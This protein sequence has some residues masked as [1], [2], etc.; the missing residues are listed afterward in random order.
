[1]EALHESLAAGV[2]SFG[3][4]VTLV[5]P[6]A[7]ATGFGSPA[8]LQQSDEME[9]YRPLR[10]HVAGRLKNQG[11]GDP[12]ASATAIL[13]LVDAEASPLRFILG[14]KN[15]PAARS[16]YAGR[17][18]GAVLWTRAPLCSG[19]GCW[20]VGLAAGSRPGVSPTTLVR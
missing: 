20:E 3:I 18:A 14:D 11:R 1:M 6:G 4:K 10:Q 9:V 5:E 8:S 2:K 17:L 19:G 7:S 16:A 15:L 13:K 12:Q